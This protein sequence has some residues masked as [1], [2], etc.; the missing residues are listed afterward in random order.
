MSVP[1][2]TPSRRLRLEN[3]R[4]VDSQP[5]VATKKYI[6]L[7]I[8]LVDEIIS[9]TSDAF[10]APPELAMS[11]VLGA[12]SIGCQH[13]I[14][15]EC[16]GGGRSPVSLFL[17]L[18]AD[19]GERKTAVESYIYK[20]IFDLDRENRIK[21]DQKNQH[22]KRDV[23]VWKTKLSHVRQE[24]TETLRESF[25]TEY[26]EERLTKVLQSEPIK[27][28]TP[29]LV[30]RDVSVRALQ[31]GM[32]ENW[33]SAALVVSESTGLFSSRNADWLPSLSAI[34]DGRPIDVQRANAS[35]L[36]VGSPRLTISL[37]LQPAIVRGY[38]GKKTGVARTAGL[39]ARFL[40]FEPISTQGSRQIHPADVG[41]RKNDEAINQLHLRIQQLLELSQES[42]PDQRKV[43]RFSP[44][45]Q[46]IWLEFYNEV[47]SE[48]GNGGYLSDIKDCASKI[49][50][51]LS[52][53]SALIHFTSGRPGDIDKE[54]AIWA[55]RRC[56]LYLDH[57][58]KVFGIRSH[59]ETTYT[60]AL[61]LNTF[62]SKKA[63]L[64]MAGRF[65]TMARWLNGFIYFEKSRLEN[66][67]PLRP[68]A[69]LDD[70]LNQLA[71][72]GVIAFDRLGQKTVVVFN[73]HVSIQLPNQEGS[74]PN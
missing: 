45:A 8:S 2:P 12:M 4:L 62:L 35:D 60:N 17:M 18:S 67:G 66:A 41:T 61:R 19:S 50:N 68:A 71:I 74:S 63:D 1:Y 52:R 72:W 54:S 46:Q 48:I 43:M 23:L 31:T 37:M 10:R 70:A 7:D 21:A 20:K 25:S 58:K 33:P 26:A 56:A 38:L 65:V 39:L 36:Y 11:A 30:Y 44:A 32:A 53:I 24:L 42:L 73:P 13:L 16:P 69:L 57:F 29:R 59:E 34:W 64:L 55:R 15:V 28:P 47:E 49:A 27:A 6:P 9:Q 3:G 51:N 14:D 40:V 22:H 5:T